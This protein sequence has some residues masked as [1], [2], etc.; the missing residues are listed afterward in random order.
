MI[1]IETLKN[2]RTEI[3]HSNR[4]KY[5]VP[6][7]RSVKKDWNNYENEIIDYP[8]QSHTD[9]LR[10]LSYCD[11]PFWKMNNI[12]GGSLIYSDPSV[13]IPIINNTCPLCLGFG[14]QN[15]YLSE[16]IIDD[17]KCMPCENGI[18]QEINWATFINSYL[19]EPDNEKIVIGFM[20]GLLDMIERWN[21][22]EYYLDEVYQCMAIVNEIDV[23]YLYGHEDALKIIHVMKSNNIDDV[24]AVQYV[25][26]ID[27]AA[28]MEFIREIKG[29]QMTW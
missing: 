7:T 16:T 20:N 4:V 19:K 14:S 11:N 9:F 13:Y 21:E 26:Q 3:S 23:E 8:L 1:K 25:K 29:E 22:K 28:A 27:E 2:V 24:S 10:K 5:Y 18:I 12:F 15:G 17:V 6:V